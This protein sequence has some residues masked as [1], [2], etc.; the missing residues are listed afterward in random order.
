MNNNNT[1]SYIPGVC[2]IGDGEIA[3][4]RKFALAGAMLSVLMI[5]VLHY[6][7]HQPRYKLLL[8]FP[9]SIAITSFLQTRY[10]FCVAFGLLGIFSF[11]SQHKRIPAEQKDY[12]RADRLKAVK[13]ITIGVAAALVLTALYYMV[14]EIVV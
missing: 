14:Y 11:D 7:S 10:R 13:I 12:L 5:V 6:F 1:T 4:R 9:L 8:F 3:G 2:N